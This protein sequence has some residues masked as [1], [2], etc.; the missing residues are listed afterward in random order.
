MS[1]KKALYAIFFSCD[2]IAIQVLVT[3]GKSVTGRY[4]FDLCLKKLKKYYHKRR[5]V[6]GFQ[7]V[8]LLHD[9]ASA[10][11][12]EIVKQ[13]LMSEKVTFLPHPPYSPDLAPTPTPRLF[14]FSKT[15]K[16]LSVHRYNSRQALGSAVSQCLRGILKSAYRD[17]FQKWIHRVKLCIPNRGEYFEGI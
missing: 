1:T 7:H 4:Y 5:P 15:E 8:C 10:H 17:A 6:T 3:K 14:P 13:F 11:T 2:C 9:N 16:F 12:S